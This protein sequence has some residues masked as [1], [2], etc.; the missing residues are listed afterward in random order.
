MSTLHVDSVMQRFGERQLLTDVFLSCNTGEIIGL[1]GSN[2]SGKSTLLKIIFGAQKANRRFVKIDDEVL[3][4]L[5]AN[6][7]RIA[8]LPQDN[9]LPNHIKI[10]TLI[11]LFCKK[12]ERQKISSHKLV[13][14]MLHKKVKQLS[15]GE[16]RLLELFLILHT[17]AQFVLIDEPFNGIA[18]VYKDE[19]KD[20]IKTQTKTKGFIITDH[21]YRNVIDLATSI[22]LLKDG[23][24]KPIK[25]SEELEQFGYLPS[26]D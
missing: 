7:S 25:N 8:Y 2:G 17:E 21:D 1:L 13:E 6:K 22:V 16:R 23:N 19:I 18:P 12:A 24:T 3:K 14:P 15:G 4:T 11:S 5:K 20:L 9:F 26:Y 10:R